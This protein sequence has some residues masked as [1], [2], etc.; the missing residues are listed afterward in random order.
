MSNGATAVWSG[1]NHQGRVGLFVALQELNRLR[2]ENSALDQNEL[3]V[4]L[5]NWKIRF[6]MLEDF[7][8][9]DGSTV[10][11]RHQVKAY[12][13][14]Q[15]SRYDPVFLQREKKNSKG[16]T[17]CDDDGNAILIDGFKCDGV[18]EDG[19][20]LHVI[21]QIDITDWDINN[22][23]IRLYEYPP[24]IDGQSGN[25]F[26]AF[27]NAT[28]EEDELMNLAI[29]QLINLTSKDKS[30][31]EIVWKDLQ[32]K[33][34]AKI[35]VGHHTAQ[36]AEFSFDE[37]LSL[38]ISNPALAGYDSDGIRRQID[39]Y[40]HEYIFSKEDVVGFTDSMRVRLARY[41]QDLISLEPNVLIKTVRYMHVDELGVH[42]AISNKVG[43]KNVI[44]EILSKV[45]DFDYEITCIKHERDGKYYVLTTITELEMGD[46]DDQRGTNRSKAQKILRSLEEEDVAL[47]FTNSKVINSKLTAPFNQLLGD[48]VLTKDFAG[49]KVYDIT[50]VGL[51]EFVSV[52]D[53]VNELNEVAT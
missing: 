9:I 51:L 17:V 38:C 35:S 29:K 27:S 25:K 6:E 5:S 50:K 2:G 19:R 16:K 21:H 8:I 32:H 53:T 30:A 47:T 24:T 7:E 52:D 44:Y 23:K 10:Y 40:Y 33:L 12:N 31:C 18:R 1:Y 37:I 42:A 45:E 49:N 26:C 20:Y 15:K 36:C 39:E 41:V 3:L 34:Q 43:L 46:N 14:T 28:A 4:F 11:S 22:Y 48:E 13:S